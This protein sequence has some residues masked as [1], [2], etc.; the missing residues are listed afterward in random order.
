MTELEWEEVSQKALQLFEF[1]QVFFFRTVLGW[2]LCLVVKYWLRFFLQATA[3]E[4]GLILVDTKYEFGKDESGN[5]FLI[6]E[7]SEKIIFYCCKKVVFFSFLLP[8]LRS[9]W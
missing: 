6:D 7:V 4:R 1:G 2:F 3:L 5:I 9:F 8:F